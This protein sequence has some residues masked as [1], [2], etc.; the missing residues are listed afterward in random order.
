[1]SVLLAGGCATVDRNQF[2]EGPYIVSTYPSPG[3]FNISRYTDIQIR[4]S[5]PMDPDTGIGFEILSK[6][7][8]VEGGKMWSDSNRVLIFRPDKPLDVNGTYQGIIREGKSKERKGLTGV[9]YLW[10]FTIKN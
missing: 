7:I 8:R 1:M 4:F 2:P 3:D 5:E 6:G 9:P 10:M